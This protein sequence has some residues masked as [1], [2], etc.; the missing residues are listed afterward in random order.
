VRSA[1]EA[2]STFVVSLPQAEPHQTASIPSSRRITHIVS[3]ASPE[4][5]E[6][7]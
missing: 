6:R 7:R 3:E 5:R 2:G 1:P 4:G